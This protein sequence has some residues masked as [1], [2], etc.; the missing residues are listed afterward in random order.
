MDF[1]YVATQ[2]VSNRS[3]AR[4]EPHET[5]ETTLIRKIG[6]KAGQSGRLGPKPNDQPTKLHQPNPEI[7]QPIESMDTF[8]DETAETVL[9]SKINDIRG[10]IIKTVSIKTVEEEPS[11]EGEYLEAGEDTVSQ[12]VPAL[13][14][15]F[16]EE[17]CG[18][19]RERGEETT[20]Q[21]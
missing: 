12:D 6:K 19:G 5:R 17:P 4:R 10:K 1:E 8:L 21:V 13:M 2:D 7:F 16:E 20:A 15:T 18:E 3:E 9:P 11:G 14:E